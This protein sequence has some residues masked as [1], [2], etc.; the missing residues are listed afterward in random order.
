[1]KL[2]CNHCGRYL[3]IMRDADIVKPIIFTCRQCHSKLTGNRIDALNG[4]KQFE[5]IKRIH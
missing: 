3:G 5:E 2:F 1:M 4:C